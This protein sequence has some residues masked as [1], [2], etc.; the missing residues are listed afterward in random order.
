[1][2]RKD[3][4]MALTWLIW[5]MYAN[6]DDYADFRSVILRRIFRKFLRDRLN[7]T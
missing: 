4:A 1:M 3:P 2:D 7:L 5:V 6:F